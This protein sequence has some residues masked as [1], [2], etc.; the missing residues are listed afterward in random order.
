MSEC[1]SG[2]V[3]VWRAF[4]MAQATAIER[5]EA[6]LELE[7][8]PAQLGWYDVLYAL[9]S[10]PERSL[11]MRELAP[12]VVVTRSWL[13]RVVDRLEAEGYVCRRSC[14]SDRRGAFVVLTEEGA[15]LLDRARA[16]FEAA[17]HEHFGRHIPDL[18]ALRA[19]LAAINAPQAERVV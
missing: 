2:E 9:H 10:A 11:R 6:E 7:G 12:R 5:I 18:E 19:M 1:H 15:A 17:V 3:Q 14:P 16:S 4:Q 13:S 8:L